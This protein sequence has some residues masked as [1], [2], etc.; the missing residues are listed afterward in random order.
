MFYFL[1]GVLLVSALMVVTLRNIFHCALFLIISLL[2]L[3]GLYFTLG[4]PFVGIMQLLIYVGAIVILI[5]FAIMLTSRIGDRLQR[6]GNRQVIPALIT[7]L[8]FIYL[9]LKALGQSAFPQNIG[10][11]FDP[12]YDL[13]LALLT[14]YMLPFEFISL[15]LLVALVGAIVMARRD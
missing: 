1:A 10:K 6:A 13:G 15:I 12:L 8:L 14:T 9:A 4:A 2:S 7:V 3:A 11:A 5:I